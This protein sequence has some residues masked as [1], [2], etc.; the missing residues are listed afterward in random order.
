MH[1]IK[2][3]MRLCSSS[4]KVARTSDN[5]STHVTCTV[6]SLPFDCLLTVIQ[7]RLRALSCDEDEAAA[8]DAQDSAVALRLTCKAFL[9][10]V[11]AA[12]TSLSLRL[13]SSRRL[14]KAAELFQGA[15]I[16]CL[17]SKCSH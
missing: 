9:S 3:K 1:A 17:T 6:M 2:S 12:V 16:H 7:H 14:Y 5:T 15:S 4:R 10:A 11:N 8:Y 13:R